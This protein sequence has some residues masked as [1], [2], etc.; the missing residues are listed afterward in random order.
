MLDAHP[1]VSH[2][3]IGCDEVYELG[4]GLSKDTIVKNKVTTEHLFLSHVR[5]I[6]EIVLKYSSDNHRKSVRPVM[7][8]DEL[9]KIPTED[10]KVRFYLHIFHHIFHNGCLMYSFI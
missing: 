4:R 3:H 9:R 7:W 6:A 8:D 5:S 10:I 2:L 1:D